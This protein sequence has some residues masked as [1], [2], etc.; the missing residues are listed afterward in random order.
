MFLPGLRK[1]LYSSVIFSCSHHIHPLFSVFLSL[2]L[3]LS[4]PLFSPSSSLWSPELFKCHE[5]PPDDFVADFT[6]ESGP[7]KFP[8]SASVLLILGLVTC[9]CAQS[10]LILCDIKDCRPPGSSIHGI[11]QAR[12]LEWV[13]IFLLQDIF[14]TLN[15][16]FF[17]LL[18]LPHWK[19]DSLL[20]C[21]LGSL[22]DLLNI[23]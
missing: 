22:W 5:K 4:L 17:S 15:L 13:A 23:V 18:S 16:N 19:A 21:Y 11:F 9:V 3:P 6:L 10:C 7:R 2:F 1:E 8:A 14:L 12:I 20:L